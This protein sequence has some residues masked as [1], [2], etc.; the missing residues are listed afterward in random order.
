MSMPIPSPLPPLAPPS[1]STTLL[2][3]LRLRQSWLATKAWVQKYAET[4][5][6]TFVLVAGVCVGVGAAYF[7]WQRRSSVARQRIDTSRLGSLDRFDNA[8]EVAMLLQG[9]WFEHFRL[10]NESHYGNWFVHRLQHVTMQCRLVEQG[11]RAGFVQILH[12]GVDARGELQSQAG[13]ARFVEHQPHVLLASFMPF[14]ETSIVVLHVD[15]HMLILGDPDLGSL[16]LLTRN[17]SAPLPLPQ[18]QLFHS[19]AQQHGY[20]RAYVL[21]ERVKRTQQG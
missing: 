4:L 14:V 18:L 21:D 12:T 9:T 8:R 10:D 13:M 11:D 19:T 20:A 15:P 2:D 6:W 3:A 7:F 5:A 1:L 17:V 16:R